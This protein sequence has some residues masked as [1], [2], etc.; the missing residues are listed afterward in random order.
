M[1]QTTAH[2]PAEPTHAPSTHAT[3]PQ[4]V[5]QPDAVEDEVLEA[6]PDKPRVLVIDDDPNVLTLLRATL[7]VCDYDITYCSN[8]IDAL[9]LITGQPYDLI[10][11]DHNMPK[12]TGLELLHLAA[13]TQPNAKRYLL[14]AGVTLDDAIE[15]MNKGE[16]DQLLRKPWGTNQLLH[17]IRDA[18]FEVQMRKAMAASRNN[19]GSAAVEMREPEVEE[20]QPAIADEP[21][22]DQDLT[23]LALE[24]AHDHLLPRPVG[25]S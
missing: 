1:T 3:T 17:E 16:V 18:V 21:N 20:R 11:S 6:A 9:R 15:A 7:S 25:K 22:N 12:M 23:R 24:M 8:A 14:T 5:K 19:A 2:S 13:R 4:A 10:L